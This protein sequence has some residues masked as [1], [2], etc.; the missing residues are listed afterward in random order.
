[1]EVRPPKPKESLVIQYLKQRVK[2]PSSITLYEVSSDAIADQD[3]TLAQQPQRLSSSLGD[4]RVIKDLKDHQFSALN[5]T[6]QQLVAFKC[7]ASESKSLELLIKQII[8][9]PH[10]GDTYVFY[11]EEGTQSTFFLAKSRLEELLYNDIKKVTNALLEKEFKSAMEGG[12]KTTGP[13]RGMGF[14]VLPEF[15]KDTNFAELEASFKKLGLTIGAIR[16]QNRNYRV[17]KKGVAPG[18]FVTKVIHDV[19]MEA[20]IKAADSMRASKDQKEEKVLQSDHSIFP[21]AAEIKT[22]LQIQLGDLKFKLQ[23]FNSPPSF[24]DV[25]VDMSTLGYGKKTFPLKDPTG[26]YNIPSAPRELAK[27]LWELLN[28]AVNKTSTRGEYQQVLLITLESIITA[29]PS[30]RSKG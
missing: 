3:R 8:S 6:G 12:D 10:K 30:P 21:K 25:E 9:F 26:K 15:K 4:V 24:L 19:D 23:L 11:L 28:A 13:Q 29:P 2:I 14:Y 22:P 18:T 1:M 20:F 16:G 17:A 27:Y 5:M 7:E